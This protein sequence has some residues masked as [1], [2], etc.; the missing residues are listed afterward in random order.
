MKFASTLALAV[1]ALAAGSPALAA[2]K[3]APAAAAP[4]AFQP[5]FSKPFRAAAGPVQ[6]ALK[7]QDAAGAKTQIDALEAVASSPDE[8][9]YVAQFRL[10]LAQMTKDTAAQSKALDDMIASGSAAVNETPGKYNYYSGI[11]AYQANDYAKAAMRLKPAS[12]A[13]YKA[14]DLN[15]MLADASFRTGQTA[16]GTAAADKAIAE[17]K[18][19]G[20]PVPEAWYRVVVSQ[21]Y[22]AKDYPTTNRYMRQLISAYPTPTNWRDALVLYRDSAK[23]DPATATDVFRLMR[24][25]KALDGE[26]DYYEYALYVDQRGLPGEAKAVIDEGYA[27]GKA[28]RTSKALA[29][30]YAS[31]SSKVA[32]DRAS[33]AS[34]EKAAAAGANGRVAANTGDA[35]LGY[36]DDAKAATLYRLAL[37]KGGVDVDAVNTHL[38]I[39]LARQGQAA[40]AKTVFSL[41]KGPRAEIANYWMTWLDQKAGTP[42]A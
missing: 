38:G 14:D 30:I 24:A 15:I 5:Q 16:Q 36:G 37:Q 12:D 32:A 8:K 6:A 3:D 40:E 21:T 19:A 27:L 26:R 28:P 31:S 20:Q 17:K 18:A 25:A 41:V 33:L 23:L 1:A 9:F 10:S 7:A 4:A 13:G 22:K 34:A 39:A 35:Y 11:S 29:D 42:A 2:K